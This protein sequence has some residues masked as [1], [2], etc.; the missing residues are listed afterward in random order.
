MKMVFQR[1]IEAAKDG[2]S[3]EDNPYELGTEAYAEW[4][5]GWLVGDAPEVWGHLTTPQETQTTSSLLGMLAQAYSIDPDETVWEAGR[6][7]SLNGGCMSDNPYEP[8][9]VNQEEWDRGFAHGSLHDVVPASELA[10]LPLP[11][12]KVVPTR[13]FWALLNN[14]QIARTYSVAELATFIG[15]NPDRIV[16]EMKD[17]DFYDEDGIPLFEVVAA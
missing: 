7:A 17:H 12:V 8:G 1:G 3:H 11:Q 9:T 2:L 10:L 13:A 14:I 16:A 4:A 15:I 5:K 6:K